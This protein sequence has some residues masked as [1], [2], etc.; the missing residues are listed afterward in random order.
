MGMDGAF[1]QSR[2][3]ARGIASLCF[4]PLLR[5]HLGRVPPAAGSPGYGIPGGMRAHSSV[6]SPAWMWQSKAAGKDGAGSAAWA[7]WARH[8]FGTFGPFGEGAPE[9][10]PAHRFLLAKG[11]KKKTL[12]HYFK[13]RWDVVAWC[14]FLPLCWVVRTPWGRSHAAQR[15]VGWTCLPA[16]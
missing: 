4:S 7:P 14:L 12:K 9:V 3:K 15:S 8:P 6:G 13:L 10:P 1:C 5:G 16:A 11:K 2:H